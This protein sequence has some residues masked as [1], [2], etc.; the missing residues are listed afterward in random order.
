MKVLALA[1]LTSVACASLAQA[2]FAIPLPKP[3]DPD[4]VRIEN[5]RLA[6]LA[7]RTDDGQYRRSTDQLRLDATNLSDADF[8]KATEAFCSRLKVSKNN[9]DIA[10]ARDSMK[11]Y[12][13][14]SGSGVRR[15]RVVHLKSRFPTTGYNR[16]ELGSY[17]RESGAK[18]SF[19]F[20]S[21]FA[22]NITDKEAYVVSNVVRGIT[23]RFIFSTDYALV[24]TKSDSTNPAK[25]DTI[26][27]DRA[28]LLRAINNGGTV[29]ARFIAPMYAHSGSNFTTAAGLTFSGG[30]IGPIGQTSEHKQRAAISGVGEWLGALAIRN[31]SGDGKLEAELVMGVRSGYTISDAPLRIGGDHKSVRFA[32]A[33]LGLR[34]NGNMSLSALFTVANNQFNDLVPRAVLNFSAVR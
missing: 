5:L 1:V 25:R 17:M 14:S 21:Q 31:L 22:A 33:V 12:L 10:L 28:N 13:Q 24:V 20:A 23:G 32:Q 6:F 16:G 29:V 4:L 34:Q 27:G 8:A 7:E 15:L 11:A 2:Q 19:S 3:V 30:L 9:C 18:E 26:E